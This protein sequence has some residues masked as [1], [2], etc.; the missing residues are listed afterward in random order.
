MRDWLVQDVLAWCVLDV[1][2][3]VGLAAI[4]GEYRVDGYGRAVF[5]PGMMVVLLLYT[6]AIGEW[7]SRAIERR[8]HVDIAFRVITAN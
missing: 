5:D 2:V 1:V 3:E 6:Y 7:S 8:C 4:Y